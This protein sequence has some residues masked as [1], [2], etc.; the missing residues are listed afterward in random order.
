MVYSGDPEFGGDLEERDR[1]YYKSDEEFIEKQHITLAVD[2]KHPPGQ[3]VELKD[4][5]GHVV[6]GACK[7]VFNGLGRLRVGRSKK[8][9][10]PF[11][12]NYWELLN[13]EDE[14]DDPPWLDDEGNALG[15]GAVKDDNGHPFLVFDWSHPPGCHSSWSGYYVGKRLVDGKDWPLTD[16]EERRLGIGIKCEHVAQIAKGKKER[17]KEKKAR[18]KKVK[19]EEVK[20]E[21]EVKVKTEENTDAD[22]S[23]RE[24]A[25][26]KDVGDKRKAS[27]G[28]MGAKKRRRA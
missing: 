1:P 20:E 9:T 13:T 8:K 3:P 11:L 28:E 5:R 14:S 15:A 4:V 24:E 12:K 6:Y 16:E 23:S 10:V 27:D 18:E 22:G 26:S 7:V 17:E 21:E 2:A 25:A 19:E